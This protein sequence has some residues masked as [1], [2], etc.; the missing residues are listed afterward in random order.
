MNAPELRIRRPAVCRRKPSATDDQKQQSMNLR[1]A[2]RAAKA[3]NASRISFRV[4]PGALAL[5][6]TVTVLTADPLN[7]KTLIS[8]ALEKSPV[9]R[10]AEKAAESSRGTLVSSRILLPANPELSYDSVTDRYHANQGEG[11]RSLQLNQVV[12]L[13]GQR[14]RRIAEAEAVHEAALHDLE[15]SRLLVTLGVKRGYLRLLV[16]NDKLKLLDDLRALSGR[17]QEASE[18]KRRQGLISDVAHQ[19]V[20]FEALAVDN[21]YQTLQTA[22]DAEVAGMRALAG[23]PE[24]EAGQFVGTPGVTPLEVDEQVLVGQ[25]L[26]RRADLLALRKLIDSRQAG[27]AL[28]KRERLPQASFRLAYSRQRSFF[29]GDNFRYVPGANPT[30]SGLAD[31]DRLITLGATFSLPLFRRNQGEIIIASSEA[32]R[33]SIALKAAESQIPTDVH[34]QMERAR[35]RQAT[36][37]RMQPALPDLAAGLEDV[38]RAFTLG[39]YSV[40]RYLVEKDRLFRARLAY[41]DALLDYLEAIVDLEQAV[42]APVYEPEISAAGTNP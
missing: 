35:G 4:I 5:L 29:S 27:V 11:G 1:A 28:L 17:V 36:L 18:A 39:E 20:A 3:S 16:M 9:I 41:D 12:E 6:S 8:T 13:W 22:R 24:I 40:D 21:D 31:T 23:M 30:I 19:I 33:L 26:N 25:A 34:R 38:T 15:A 37:V 10:E 7:L 42:G 14:G 32:D 2:N